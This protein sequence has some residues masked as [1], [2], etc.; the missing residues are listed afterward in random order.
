MFFIAAGIYLFDVVVYVLFAS[1]TEQPWNKPKEEDTQ[2]VEVKPPS[3]QS[4]EKVQ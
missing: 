1:G 3:A 4:V 2:M